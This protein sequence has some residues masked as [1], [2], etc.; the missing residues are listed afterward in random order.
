MKT[1][2]RLLTICILI[3]SMCFV[4]SGC[5]KNDKSNT[6]TSKYSDNATIHTYDENNIF[7]LSSIVIDGMNVELTINKDKAKFCDIKDLIGNTNNKQHTPKC[8]FNNRWY[9]PESYTCITDNNKI[10]LNMKFKNQYNYD[11]FSYDD[12]MTIENFTDPYIEYELR[13]GEIIEYYTQKYNQKLK[14]WDEDN[15]EETLV[16]LKDN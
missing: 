10:I 11:S 14:L 1:I 8:K 4:L 7:G 6:N 9:T 2:V 15:H 3:F 5:N 16:P 13:G 12:S